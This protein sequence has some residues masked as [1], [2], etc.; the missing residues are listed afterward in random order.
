MIVLGC[1]NLLALKNRCRQAERKFERHRRHR[2]AKIGAAADLE[3]VPECNGQGI[4][5]GHELA[6]CILRK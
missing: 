5:T 2:M 1:G 6:K 4:L 3:V